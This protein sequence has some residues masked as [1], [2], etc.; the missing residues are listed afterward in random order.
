MD[1]LSGDLS[2]NCILR[3]NSYGTLLFQTW[4]CALSC[5]PLS[6]TDGLFH[7]CSNIRDVFFT[8][9]H[10][11]RHCVSVRIRVP[12]SSCSTGLLSSVQILRFHCGPTGPMHVD[13]TVCGNNSTIHP[14]GTED[15]GRPPGS[16]SYSTFDAT[17]KLSSFPFGLLIGRPMSTSHQ[18]QCKGRL[19]FVRASPVPICG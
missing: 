1:L 4:F 19:P 13:A 12:T 16:V 18:L 7:S 14:D 10:E 6:C 2:K 9:R 8:E 5:V 3:Y 15:G 17:H 11:V